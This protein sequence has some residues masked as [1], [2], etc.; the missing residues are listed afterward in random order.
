MCGLCSADPETRSQERD[1]LR[2]TARR[3]ETIAAAYRNMAD[4]K[5][6]PHDNERI[7]A[8]DVEVRTAIVTL[9]T[10]WL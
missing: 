7:E 10:E 2:G 4:G 3:L 5:L 8:L 9:A 6:G 1:A